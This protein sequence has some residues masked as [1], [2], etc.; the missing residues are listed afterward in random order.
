MEDKSRMLRLHAA[1]VHRSLGGKDN[2]KKYWPLWGDNKGKEINILEWD[3]DMYQ[4]V[5]KIHGI[6]SKKK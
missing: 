3:N 6:V 2:E 1:V 5:K 4:E